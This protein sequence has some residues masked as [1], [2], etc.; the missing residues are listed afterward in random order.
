MVEELGRRM[1]GR[2]FV[3]SHQ[4]APGDGPAAV[5]FVVSAV[6]P[7][8][9]SDCALADLATAHTGTVVAVVS[10]VDDHRHWRQVLARNREELA[11][12]V[13]RLQHV[14][15]V[16]AAAAPRL[17]EPI[18]DGLV[19]VLDQ[20]LDDPECIRRNDLRA[21]ES[22]LRAEMSRWDARAAGADRKVRV[23]AL[24]ERR[25]ELLGLRL[26]LGPKGAIA[27]RSRIQ[28]ARLAL[29]YSARNHCATARAELLEKAAGQ[30]RVNWGE[31][32]QVVRRRCRD[33]VVEVDEEIATHIE[34]VAADL[35]LAGPAESP[36][37][38]PEA[39]ASVATFDGPPV[40]SRRLET[41]L[42]AVLG[43]GFGLGVAL[44]VSRFFAGLAPRA[45]VAGLVAG[46]VVG[47]AITVWVVRTRRLLTDRAV[48]DRWVND[49]IGVVRAAVEERVA[50]SVLDAEAALSSAHVAGV[51]EQRRAVDLRIA[52]VDAELRE[53]TREIARAEAAREREMPPLLRA[54]RA[55]REALAESNPT[56]SVVTGR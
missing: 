47:V 8:S 6:A 20:Q 38:R 16:G 27:L 45:T 3:E 53:L 10:K 43:A 5:V 7:L 42:M 1:P 18:M 19:E 49:V 55:V 9:D 11:E 56:E 39:R 14:R 36:R 25:E 33:I 30:G 52:G 12:S 51:A 37:Q 32:D 17:G 48:L 41:Q 2:N 22:R 29:T 28:R 21:A 13:A 50:T 40:A 34:E 24:R 4:H 15:W 31:F 44:L 26:L 46:G 54:L 23:D 35:D